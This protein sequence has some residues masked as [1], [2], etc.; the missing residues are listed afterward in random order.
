MLASM[1]PTALGA[2]STD[3]SESKPFYFA[4]K[5][6]MAYD[7]ALTPNVGVEIGIGRRFTFSAGWNYGW[8]K[9]ADNRRWCINAGEIDLRYYLG[10]P[11]NHKPMTGHHIGI[12]GLLGTYDFQFSHHGHLGGTPGK[13]DPFSNPSYAVG[14]EYG[15]SLPVARRI[16]IDFGI[17]FGYMGGKYYEY[18]YQDGHNVWEQTNRSHWWGPTKVEVSLVWLIGRGNENLKGGDR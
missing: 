7:V 18:D 16:N 5:T 17:G 6:N 10:T 9:M 14:I 15:Y 13:S 1:L 3:G 2:D 4:A 11:S 8:W 12:Y